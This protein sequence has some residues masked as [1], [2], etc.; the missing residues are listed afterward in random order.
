MWS[1]FN[2]AKGIQSNFND[3]EMR[4]EGRGVQNRI[5]FFLLLLRLLKMPAASLDVHCTHF[6]SHLDTARKQYIS[7]DS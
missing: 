7:E 6:N 3:I 4:N 2:G 5:L 1:E